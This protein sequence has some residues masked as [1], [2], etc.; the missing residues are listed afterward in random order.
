MCDSSQL[1][2]GRQAKV[3][4]NNDMSNDVL[5]VV[6]KKTGKTV[7]PKDIHKIASGV[8]PSTLQSD[9]QL[10]QLIKQVSSLVNVDVSEETVNEIIHAV[11]SSN[12]DANNMQQL[13]SM[14]L[15]KK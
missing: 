5:N 11:K 9:A 4:N 14:M 3:A 13:M 15:G 12:L 10:R 6:K 7:S 2:L 8:K 1:Q